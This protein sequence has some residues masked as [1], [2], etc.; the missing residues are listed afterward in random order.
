MFDTRY[1]ATV[2]VAR[3]IL[4]EQIHDECHALVQN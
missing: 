3:L 4:F 1:R 2:G